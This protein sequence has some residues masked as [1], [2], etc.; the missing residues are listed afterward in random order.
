MRFLGGL[1]CVFLLSSSTFAQ[2]AEQKE[3]QKEPNR[4]LLIKI[5]GD[6]GING[7]HPAHPSS[8]C[9]LYTEGIVMVNHDLD[10]KEF[11]VTTTKSKKAQWENL[12]EIKAKIDVAAKLQ[13]TTS[14]LAQALEPSIRYAAVKLELVTTEAAG[15]KVV[16][17]VPKIIQLYTAAANE[18]K[19]EG[20]E[21]EWL[22]SFLDENCPND[23]AFKD[24]K[25]P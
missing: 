21:V 11:H 19:R 8:S 6:L 7:T 23:K 3:K 12:D 16:Y 4:P 24:L 14:P 2:E 1:L 20:K 18:S 9:Q 17:T 15:E 22:I 5:I 25:L 13:E 10:D